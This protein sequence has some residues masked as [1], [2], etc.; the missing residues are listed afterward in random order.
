MC[1]A[2]CLTPYIQDLFQ[3][4]TGSSMTE[5]ALLA[6][7]VAVVCVLAFLALGKTA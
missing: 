4:E 5:F 2:S 1:I 6:S 3:E 7:L